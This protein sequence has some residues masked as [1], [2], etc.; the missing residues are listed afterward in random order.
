MTL[1]R[2]LSSKME[3][4]S[5]DEKSKVPDRDLSEMSIR[6]MVDDS[7]REVERKNKINVKSDD[8]IIEVS[9]R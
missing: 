3:F 1:R 5:A 6:D 9:A 2:K 8:R 7:L 4:S